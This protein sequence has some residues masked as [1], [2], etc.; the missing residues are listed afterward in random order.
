MRFAKQNVALEC[1]GK[2]HY[3]VEVA[4]TGMFFCQNRISSF[5]KAKFSAFVEQ[6]LALNTLK[7]GRFTIEQQRSAKHLSKYL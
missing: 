4:V 3:F 2:T 1:Q 5:V 6:N 7:T